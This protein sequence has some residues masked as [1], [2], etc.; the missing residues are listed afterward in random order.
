MATT[1]PSRNGRKNG[2]ATKLSHARV[3]DVSIRSIRPSPE[4]NRLYRP[5][6]PDD[7]DIQALAASIRELGV[8]EPLVLSQ[9]NYILSGHRRY[10]AAGLAGLK[11]VPVRFEDI[12]RD[13][14]PDRFL[15]LLRE[16]NRQREKSLDEKLREEIVSADPDEAYR[17]LA[18]YRDEQSQVDM[19]RLKISGTKRRC[20][21]SKA[22]GPF[23]AAIRKIINA[24]RAYWPLSD[25]LI[26]Y[27]LL[28]DP[29]LKHASKPDSTYDN[30]KQSWNSLTE[31]LT[32][33]RLANIIPM[34]AIADPTRPVTIW[35][36]HPSPTEFVRK[37]L[38]SF[39]KGYYRDF[40]RSQ[41]NHI[42]IVA[43]KNT[44]EPIVRQVAGEYRIP[45]TSG[46]GYCSLPPR[47]A[48]AERYK[49][50]GKEK[51][52]LLMLTDF[53]PDGE[54]IAHSFARSMRDDFAVR[55]IHPVKV[56]LTA[57]QVIDLE[58]PPMMQAKETSAH[59]D[60]FVEKHGDDVF[61][62]EALEEDSLQ[63]I[64]REAIDSVIDIE[65]F[66][67]EVDAEHDDAVFLAAVRR[68]VHD[69]LAGVDELELEL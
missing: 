6:D 57:E 30:T 15:L 51:L 28:N 12:D 32:R 24:R 35:R 66:N 49:R 34:E 17:A 8:R 14:D 27:R 47:A 62:L 4:N 42:E 2:T 52:I 59:Y 11:T 64:L 50:S 38:D 63:D 53:D 48:M 3:L 37:E 58:L 43:E 61:E 10:V 45:V 13:D 18:D 46:R 60:K 54:E 40:Q 56:A 7:P 25:R 39:L 1:A 19:P 22:K 23:L 33:A 44:I 31:L 9:D 41:P 20:H 21:I 26:H 36:V 69:A 68:T 16:A 29:P 65:A 55:K 67:A 5:V